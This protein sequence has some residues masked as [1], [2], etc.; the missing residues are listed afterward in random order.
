ME[1]VLGNVKKM[2]IYIDNVTIGGRNLEEWML[3]VH[4]LFEKLNKYN[5]RVNIDKC[6]FFKQNVQFL[7]HNFGE[8]QVKLIKEKVEAIKKAKTTTN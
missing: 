8:N 1:K 4:L 5:I 3:N 6:K 7:C 2:S